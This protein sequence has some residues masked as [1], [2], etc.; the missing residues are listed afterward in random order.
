MSC[1]LIR[2]TFRAPLSDY[3]FLDQRDAQ[4]TPWIRGPFSA[5]REWRR[6]FVSERHL[7][8]PV[9]DLTGLN[10]RALQCT[11]WVTSHFLMKGPIHL[12]REWRRVFGSEGH[13]AHPVSYVA[14]LSQGHS[15]HPVSLTLHFWIRGTFS[16][17]REWCR[18]FGSN[19]HSA[20][21]RDNHTLLTIHL[22]PAGRGAGLGLFLYYG[23]MS[24]Y[25]GGLRFLFWV[26][27]FPFFKHP[28]HLGSNP[29][30]LWHLWKYWIQTI[31]NLNTLQSYWPDNKEW[32]KT[33]FPILAMFRRSCI[34]TW[35]N[36]SFN[37]HHRAMLCRSHDRWTGN[38]AV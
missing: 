1:F 32:D 22:S 35:E 27:K 12:F 26:P 19:G 11:P 36:L 16:A 33:A 2:R 8:H 4:R 5:P 3:T 18:V 15:V 30:N 13:S 7:A 28:K 14:F 17:P 23:G 21:T 9:N 37:V 6:V 25:K 10:Q 31:E 38:F 34:V 29:R 20:H 24:V